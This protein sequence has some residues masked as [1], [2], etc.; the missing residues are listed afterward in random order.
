VPPDAIAQVIQQFDNGEGL[1]WSP[2][3]RNVEGMERRIRE[4]LLM[5]WPCV[6]VVSV[7]GSFLASG[8]RK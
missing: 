7:L 1:L 8:N 6:V 4:T 3:G 2:I 5:T